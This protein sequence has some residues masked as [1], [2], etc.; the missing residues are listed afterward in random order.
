MVRGGIFPFFGMSFSCC[1]KDVRLKQRCH[2]R[3]TAKEE[4][5]LLLKGCTIEACYADNYY[6]SRQ[7]SVVVE[8]RYDW[9]AL[10]SAVLLDALSGFSC[11]WKDVRLK[12]C[13]A[14]RAI[15]VTSFSCCWKDVR[16]KPYQRAGYK[17]P[18]SFQLL[19]KGCTIE[20]YH[21]TRIPQVPWL[22]FQLLLKGCT[23]EA[24]NK[25][26]VRHH[27]KV[28]VVVE[29]MYDWSSNCRK[30]SLTT[31]DVSVVVER[32]YDWSRNRGFKGRNKTVSVVV[33]RMYDWSCAAPAKGECHGRFS[34]C[35]K[36]VRLKLA[37]L[38]NRSA[39][40]VVSVV[41]ERMY[42]WSVKMQQTSH[43][44][45]L[46]SVVVE[47]MYDWSI[48]WSGEMESS[49]VSVVVERMYDW[50]IK[51]LMHGCLLKTFQLLLKG[52]TIEAPSQVYNDMIQV[53]FQLCL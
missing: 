37:Q 49:F 47:R 42:D 19:L 44:T 13:K 31:L 6:T 17:Q 46:V 50:S 34:C 29:R 39:R 12:R 26:R 53:A 52:C 21:C 25:N 43:S 24:A 7:V 32:M 40:L 9:S 15:K 28:S 45:L 22:R 33:E 51:K 23:I 10:V 30:S 5:Q 2:D 35:W 1:W 3:K 38:T 27:R 48:S 8:R 41:V 4:F 18:T 36:D 20:A 14:R 16:L 11:C